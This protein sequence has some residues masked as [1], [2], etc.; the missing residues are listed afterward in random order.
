MAPR[1]LQQPFTS[2]FQV[3][4]KQNVTSDTET[5]NINT[6]GHLEKI[7]CAGTGRGPIKKKKKIN[8][9]GNTKRRSHSFLHQSSVG[10]V[11]L[12]FKP[13]T[14]AP[15]PPPASL[16]VFHGCFLGV[17]ST[18]KARRVFVRVCVFFSPENERWLPSSTREGSHY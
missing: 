1:F 16:L 4:T 9:A 8:D 7:K 11:V 18:R 13:P 10:E 5:P 17:V 2:P 15:P 14:T 12:V 6:K 3:P